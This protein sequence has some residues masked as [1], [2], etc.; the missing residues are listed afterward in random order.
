MLRRCACEL[1]GGMTLQ[2]KGISR[3]ERDHGDWV[4]VDELIAAI[5]ESAL[6]PERWDRLPELI[7][8]RL[9]AAE[10][11]LF[12]CAGTDLR[13]NGPFEARRTG[14]QTHVAIRLS[15][16]C[17]WELRLDQFP[18][19]DQAVEAHGILLQLI[20]HLARAIA[21]FRQHLL[22]QSRQTVAALEQIG[23]GAAI[24][25]DA[26]RVLA[27]NFRF[28]GDIG[29]ACVVGPDSTLRLEAR[30]DDASM[31]VMLARTMSTGERCAVPIRD[32]VGHCVAA[33]H[34]L[35]LGDDAI[36]RQALLA[37]VAR[38]GS[39]TL[40]GPLLLQALFG[41]TQ[42]EAKLARGIAGGA[43]LGKVAH[44][45]GITLET[46]RSHIKRIFSKTCTTR[47]LELTI[48][49]RGFGIANAVGEAAG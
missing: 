8:R 34:L 3:Y 16:T 48:L 26:G 19:A 15:S 28:A 22:L 30:R 11:S 41:L 45:S 5:Y 18:H 42:A 47:Q 6:L 27:A 39:E 36:R 14:R 7:A 33:L 32:D 4:V 12:E 9:G 38:P 1:G 44:A 40:P 2:Y 46:A 17:E 37:L 29:R 10:G 31:R 49:I 23:A 13:G 43:T 35:P 20:P 24:I 25:D 21:I